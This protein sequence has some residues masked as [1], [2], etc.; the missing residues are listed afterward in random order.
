MAGKPEVALGKILAGVCL[1][2]LRIGDLAEIGVQDDR[3]VEFDPDRRTLDSDFLVIPLPGSPQVTL[4]GRDH[5][6]SRTVVLVGCQLARVAGVENLQFAHPHVSRVA[7]ARVPDRQPVVAGLGQLDLKSH[8][9]ITVL[10]LGEEVTTLALLATNGPVDDLVVV[11]RAGPA[12]ESLA[13]ENRLETAFGLL[14]ENPVGFLGADFPDINVPPAD[15]ATMCLKLNR[16]VVEQR[17]LAIEVVFQGGV[18]DDQFIIEPHRGAC[19]D[20]ADSETVPLPQLIVGQ[21][22][23]VLSLGPLAVVP[24]TA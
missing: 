6:V 4:C 18:V 3:P 23:R 11:D 2:S 24:Q 21:D 12:I 14:A 16:T 10:V 17:P 8:H 9:E 15:L 7:P 5:P 19:S 13:V 22:Q 1:H 20:L